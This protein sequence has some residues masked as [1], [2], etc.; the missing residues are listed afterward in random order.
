MADVEKCRSCGAPVIWCMTK[1]GRHKPVN[2]EPVGNGNINL[3]FDPLGLTVPVAAVV[4]AGKGSH[5]SHFATC[6]KADQ[7]RK[8]R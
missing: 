5:V 8:R 7:W 1:H 4:A 2:A 6:P 3:H